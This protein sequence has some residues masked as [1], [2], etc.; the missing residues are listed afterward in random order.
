MKERINNDIKVFMKSRNTFNLM[1]VRSVKGAIQLVEINK[2]RDL[3]DDEIIEIINKQ[4]KLRRDSIEEFKKG[5]RN[6]L[7]EKAQEEINI[8]MVYMPIQLTEGEIN[9][10]IDDIFNKT[11]PSGIKDLGIVMK[12]V[13]PIVK[14]KSDMSV[15]SN[16]IKSRLQ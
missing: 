10:I 13:T 9:K 7:I 6:D 4:I 2:K 15:V 12:E 5:N 11:N 8:L 16:I 14:G 1:V 3:T